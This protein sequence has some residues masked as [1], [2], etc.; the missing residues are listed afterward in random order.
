[1]AVSMADITKL[2]KMTG[3][4]M[5]DCKNALT[6]AEGD[7]DKAMEIIRKK[8]QAVAAKRSDREASE[9]CVLAKTTGDFAV[10]IALKCETDFVAQ[11]ADFVKLTQDILGNGTVQDAVTDRSG[12][13]GEKMELDGYMTVEGAST[14]VYNHMNRNGLCTIVAFNK[15]VEMCK[16]DTTF[17]WSTSFLSI[18][19]DLVNLDCK[20]TFLA[21]YNGYYIDP[22]KFEL[23]KV[24]PAFGNVVCAAIA[25]AIGA[26]YKKIVLLGCDFNSFAF[27]HEVHCYDG[28]K[29]NKAVRRISLGYELFC[30][31]FDAFVHVQLAEYARTLGVEIINSTKGSLIDAYPMNVDETLY[32]TGVDK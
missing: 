11:N 26:G 18:N 32:K 17:V 14:V 24:M 12:I 16:K 6:E 30:Y 19:P 1:M 28:G 15:A 3:A 8:G 29:E 9:G 7:F 25:F 5:M 27:P 4:G 21:M 10:I 22:K 2:R 23:T 20:K 31:C 13:T